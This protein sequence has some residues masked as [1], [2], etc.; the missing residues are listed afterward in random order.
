MSEIKGCLLEFGALEKARRQGLN[1]GSFG[2]VLYGPECL[3]R[4][5][6]TQSGLFKDSRSIYVLKFVIVIH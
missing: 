4:P 5:S 1:F 2:G 3:F 6:T